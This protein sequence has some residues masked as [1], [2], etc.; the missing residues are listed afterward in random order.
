MPDAPND[1]AGETPAVTPP[2]AAITPPAQ[3][4]AASDAELA[5]LKAQLAETAMQVLAA[6][7]ENLRD[8]IPA[9][10][11]PADQIAWFNKAKATGVFDKPAVPATPAITPA[12][13][14]A[15][16]DTA[17]LPIYARLAAGYSKSA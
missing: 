9:N 8:L 12:I 6:V 15:T 11:S 13:T 5:A 3:T 2:A 10:L 1:N 14:P 17:S 16:P 7:P 4:P